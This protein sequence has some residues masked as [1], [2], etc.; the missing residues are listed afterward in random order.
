[1]RTMAALL[2]IGGCA[3]PSLSGTTGPAT[4][5][6]ATAGPRAT[7]SA[8]S[9]PTVAP[10]VAGG[11][12]AP[13]DSVV[14]VDARTGNVVAT[15]LVGPD[16]KVVEVAAGQVWTLD[17]GDGALSRI[18]P[19]AREAVRLRV[20][21][22]AVGMASDGADLWVAHDGRFLSRLDGRSGEV[23]ATLTLASEPLF[24]LRN[25]GFVAV[26]E[27]TGWLTVPLLGRALAPHS[28]WEVDLAT[29]A[30]VERYEVGREPGWPVVGEGAV[31]LPVMGSRD[32]ARLDLVTRE[33]D[34][35]DGGAAPVGVALGDGSAWIV[36][37][38]PP[39]LVRVEPVD[40]N[41]VAEVELDAPARGIVVGGGSIW[42][43]TEA[44]LTEVDPATTTVRRAIRLV[45]PVRR[46]SGPTDAAYL[47][48][49]VWVAIE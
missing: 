33:L 37:E 3:A 1:M 31:W 48:G 34:R 10:T 25:A 32:V 41:V 26:A 22:D 13:G 47:D 16:P 9:S 45:D 43:T 23:R 24:A 38:R 44:G 4:F 18:D 11:R 14:A 21:G 39:T 15:I 46:G 36:D 8:G 17:L 30:T 20:T 27:G 29:G 35:I 5:A 19:V 28:L 42:T 40:G 2:L 7:P 49:I 6:T 12:S